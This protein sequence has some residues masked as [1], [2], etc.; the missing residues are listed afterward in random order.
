MSYWVTKDGRRIAYKNIDDRHLMNILRF[1][2]KM[3]ID[4][5]VVRSGGGGS[6]DEIWYDEYTIYGEEVYNFFD[7]YGLLKEAKRR[8]IVVNDNNKR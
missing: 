8:G 7:Y 3:A 2:E 5:Y 6:I 4:G 1:I